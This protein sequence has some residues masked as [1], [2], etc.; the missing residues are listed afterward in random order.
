MFGEVCNSESIAEIHY[1]CGNRGFTGDRMVFTFVFCAACA[2]RSREF[3]Y[4]MKAR[5]PYVRYTHYTVVECDIGSEMCVAVET[6][7]H[8]IVRLYG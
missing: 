3:G 2:A 8:S 4:R 6:L 1:Y 5:N 7:V